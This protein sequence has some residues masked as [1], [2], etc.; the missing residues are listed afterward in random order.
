MPSQKKQKTKTAPKY[1]A[2]RPVTN[3]NHCSHLRY[4]HSHLCPCSHVHALHAATRL[5]PV[6]PT[7]ATPLTKRGTRLPSNPRVEVPSSY[8]SHLGLPY[9]PQSSPD[10]ALSLIT[11]TRRSIL[12]SLVCALPAPRSQPQ[13]PVPPQAAKTRS[14]CPAASWTASRRSTASLHRN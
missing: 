2:D 4:H 1:S 7:T 10:V 13:N 5:G 3:S 12:P 11:S 6:L 14:P 8:A 9:L